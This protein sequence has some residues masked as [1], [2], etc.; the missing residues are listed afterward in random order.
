MKK[1]VV[2]LTII[3]SMLVGGVVHAGVVNSEMEIIKSTP[4]VASIGVTFEE[5]E[6]LTPAEKAW[7]AEL[8]VCNAAPFNVPDGT[9]GCKSSAITYMGYTAVTSKASK[10]YQILRGAGAWSD[11]STGLRM[12]GDRVCIALGSGYAKVG[13]KVDL[14][15]ANGNVIKCIVGDAK[16]DQHTDPTNRFHAVDGSVAEMIVDYAYFKKGT[17]YYGERIKGKI[18][19]VVVIERC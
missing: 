15:M 18:N 1:K 5:I 6:V 12:V 10:Q 14:V 4:K 16:A 17:N 3:G 7:Q 11:P 13:D 9:A 8:A 19:K 2:M